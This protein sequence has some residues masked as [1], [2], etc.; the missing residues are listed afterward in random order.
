MENAQGKLYDLSMIHS[1]SGGDDGFIKQM[2]TLFINTTP[3]TL[4]DLNNA[5]NAANW[6]QVSKSAHKLKSTL[7]SMG[8]AS[9]KDD[10]RFVELHAK[11]SEHLDQIPALI[12]KINSIT[13]SCIEQLQKEIL[14]KAA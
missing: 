11:K 8:I 1:I 13:N 12:D 9:L 4:D 7:D 6:D 14:D 10:I 3:Q 2:V 5:L